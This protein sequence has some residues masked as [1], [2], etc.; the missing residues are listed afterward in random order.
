MPHLVRKGCSVN[1]EFR[2]EKEGRRAELFLVNTI[3]AI[4][5]VH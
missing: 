2:A 3:G 4:A 1:D 5:A